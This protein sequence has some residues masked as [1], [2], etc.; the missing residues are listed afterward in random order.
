MRRTAMPSSPEG[1]R[2]V[3]EEAENAGTSLEGVTTTGVVR[4]K[5][6]V[7]RSRGSLSSWT[8]RATEVPDAPESGVVAC[9]CWSRDGVERHVDANSLLR[10]G[11]IGPW[12]ISQPNK[13][14]QAHLRTT[15]VKALKTN[16]Q[17][18]RYTS[19]CT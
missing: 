7:W 10:P 2:P 5:A 11:L 9:C 12:I 19:R 13:Q 16:R 17:V 8:R 6:E 14:H 15:T 18:Y 3:A 4:G 1:A